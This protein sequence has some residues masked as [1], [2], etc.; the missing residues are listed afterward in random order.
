MRDKN[1]NH[2]KQLADIFDFP[3]ADYFNKV[4]AAEELLKDYNPDTLSVLNEFTRFLN[5]TPPEKVE[6]LYLRTFD[7][8]AVTT[9]DIGYVLFGD[10]YKRGELLVNLSKEHQ[11]ADNDCGHELADHL[12]NLLR[13]IPKITDEEFRYELVEMIILPALKKII[14]EFDAKNIDM[15]NSVYKR[16]YKTLIEQ[17]ESY[18]RMFLKPLLVIK[19]VLEE[20]FG[21]SLLLEE[22]NDLSFT[23]SIITEIKI[24]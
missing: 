21:S 8:Q 9:L 4:K 15:K 2:Y 5:I 23:N 1:L 3:R 16:K 7:I 12:P 22:Q 20:D 6:E 24:D 17:P 19:K 14:K 18:G 13:L 10:D 11:K